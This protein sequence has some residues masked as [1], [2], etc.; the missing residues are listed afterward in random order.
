MNEVANIP[1]APCYTLSELVE[2]YMINRHISKEKYFVDYMVIA[3]RA[4]QNLFWKTL[5]VVQTQWLTIQ[6]G[7]PYNFI[8]V[9]KGTVRIMWVGVTDRHNRIVQLHIN[10]SLNVIPKPTVQKCGCTV[11]GC[12]GAKDELVG[13]TYTTTALFTINGITYYEKTWTKLCSNGDLLKYREVPVKKYNDRIGNAGDFNNDFNQDF[14]TG[15]PGSQNFTIITETF[16]EK[17]CALTIAPCG[18][19]EPTPQNA[20]CI[21]DFCGCGHLFWGWWGNRFHSENLLF[22]NIN[23]NHKG[24]IKFSECGNKIYYKESRHWCDT[25][26]NPVPQFLLICTQSSGLAC[27]IDGSIS[28]PEYSVDYMMSDI[29][30]RSKRFNAKYSMAEKKDAEWRKNDELNKVIGFLNP[31]S[32]DWLQ[33]VMDQERKW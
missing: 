9:P 17:V 4:W 22:Q 28:V 21:Q 30:Y 18:C 8:Y 31:I 25:L 11:C 1:T 19:P 33:N 13:L 20:Q 6:K 12:T 5:Q 23:D 24:E 7:E 29:D 2:E 26:H 15:N 32:L 16:Q 10:N 3:K 14:S 27:D